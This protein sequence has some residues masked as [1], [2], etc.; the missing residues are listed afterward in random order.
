SDVVLW[1][2]PDLKEM[3]NKKEVFYPVIRSLE[4]VSLIVKTNYSKYAELHKIKDYFEKY[5][6]PFKGLVL[7]E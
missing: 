4:S 3:D 2:L 7:A 1:D 5:K 6:V